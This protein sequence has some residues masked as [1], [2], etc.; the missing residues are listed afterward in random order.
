MSNVPAPVREIEE[1]PPMDDDQVIERVCAGEIELFEVVMR[2]YNQRIYRT[3]RS[4]LRDD[5]EAV[6]VMQEAY[7]NAYSHLRDFS[8]RARFST[9]LT[10]IAV[11]EAFARLRRRRRLEPLEDSD[12]EDLMTAQ[13][14]G[15]DERASDGELRQFLEEAVDTLPEA[16]RT[17]FMLRAVEHL[18][19]AETAEV[20]GIPEE[21]VKTRHHRARERLQN[22]LTERVG[23]ALPQ[24]FGFHR[25]RCDKVVAF[26]LARIREGASQASAPVEAGA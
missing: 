26:V 5:D 7:L 2:R 17:T 19:V 20:L 6:D 18:S 3:V 21:T 23:E 14:P 16:F 10:R 15:P 11:H 4:I 8:G 9:W 1:Q 25:P 12:S 24:L 22:A 13:S